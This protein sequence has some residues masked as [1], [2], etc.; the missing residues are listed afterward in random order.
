MKYQHRFDVNATVEKVNSFHQ[1]AKSLKSITPPFFFM[2][3][4]KAPARLS[5]GDEMAFTLWMGP[6][7]VRWHARIE[8]VDSYGFD[9][10]QTNGPFE[11]WTHR[12]RF[13]RIND[14]VTRVVDNIEYTIRR[15]WFWGPIGVGMALG[16]PILFWYRAHRT[17]SI[18]EGGKWSE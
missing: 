1:S 4:I 12:H 18:I 10:V 14:Q 17:K 7:P 13:E 2:S 15:H 5:E 11:S 16:L 6:L 8:N 3:G 9:D